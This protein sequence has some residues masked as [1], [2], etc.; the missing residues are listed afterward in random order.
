MANSNHP[1]LLH[2]RHFTTYVQD[3]KDLKK[4]R[5]IEGAEKI[6]IDLIL[7]TEAED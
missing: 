2:G 5:D 3:V 7:V 4:E 1:G 6:L